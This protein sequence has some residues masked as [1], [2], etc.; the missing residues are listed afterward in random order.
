[1]SEAVGVSHLGLNPSFSLPGAT[2]LTKEDDDRIVTDDD[3]TSIC[4][5]LQDSYSSSLSDDKTVEC[6][7]RECPS[8]LHDQFME[9][10]P[11]INLPVGQLRILTLC[12]QTSNDMTSWSQPVDEEREELLGHFIDSAKEIC[13]RLMGAGYWADFVD[14][15]SGRAVR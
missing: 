7:L 3:I 15:S 9:L 8:F 14:P 13:S 2:G 12:E 10:F 5:E 4:N 1:V 11:G 6:N